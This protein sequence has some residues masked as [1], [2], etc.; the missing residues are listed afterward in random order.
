MICESFA[1]KREGPGN[2][3]AAGVP[4]QRQR[5]RSSSLSRTNPCESGKSAQ[6][7]EASVRGP[8]RKI[9]AAD[10]AGVRR[11]VPAVVNPQVAQPALRNGYREAL[12]NRRESRPHVGGRLN[13]NRLRVARAIKPLDHRAPF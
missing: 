3:K 4:G 2:L 8:E 1:S 10:G 13:R 11:S 7:E 9:Q 6:D 12:A 5:L